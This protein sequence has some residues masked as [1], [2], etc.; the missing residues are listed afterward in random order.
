M[1]ELKSEIKELKEQLKDKAARRDDLVD[2]E[3]VE[4]SEELDG[5]I[6]AY[7]QEKI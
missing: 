7:Y 2:R 3:V 5:K 1:E 4:L 6:L